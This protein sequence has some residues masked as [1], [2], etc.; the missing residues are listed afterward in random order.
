MKRTFYSRFLFRTAMTLLVTATPCFCLTGWAE[1]GRTAS[2][3]DVTVGEA[4]SASQHLPSCSSY[5]YS[6]TEQIYTP[7]EIGTAGTINAIAFYNVGTEVTRN[8]DLYLVHTDKTEF[9]NKYDWIEVKADDKVFSGDVTM[10]VGDWTRIELETPFE[11]N[12]EQSLAVIVDD[13]TGSKTEGNQYMKCLVYSAAGNQTIHI[14]RTNVNYDPT[15]IYE[16]EDQIDEERVLGNKKNQLRFSFTTTLELTNDGTDNEAA[17]EAA[18]T[19]GN[20]YNVKLTGRTLYKDGLWNT[21]CLPFDVVLEGSPLEGAIAKTLTDASTSPSELYDM[22]IDL[23]FGDAVTTLEAGKPYII[24]WD[25]AEGY[26]EADPDTRDITEPEFTNVTINDAT[27]N[28]TISLADG[29]VQFIGYYNAFDIDE[30]NDDIY[31]MK[32]GNDG[33]T[34]L[35]H[36]SVDRTLMACRAYFKFSDAAANSKITLNLDDETT[37]ITTTNATNYTNGDDSWY[38]LDGRKLVQQ[39]TRKGVYIQNGRAVVIK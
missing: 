3:G 25:K 14:H 33:N 9:E 34:T 22:H 21:L 16:R 37:G 7:D 19:S 5:K 8:F 26:D 15:T 23:I 17:I 35:V 13:N 39:P 28:Q 6:V 20:H 36:T 18:A 31:Y 29:N 27:D 10:V 32:A 24:R 1:N 38:S 2:D 4:S 30:T 11:Y 12:G